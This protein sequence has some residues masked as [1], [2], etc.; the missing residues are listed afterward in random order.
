MSQVMTWA[1]VAAHKTRKDCYPGGEE[2]MIE[3]AGADATEAFD[4]IGHSDDAVK[5]LEKYLIGT[6][7]NATPS[8]EPTKPQPPSSKPEDSGASKGWFG[9]LGKK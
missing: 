4:D 2:V 5:L 9:W 6:V 1:E 3:Q 8:K 7:E